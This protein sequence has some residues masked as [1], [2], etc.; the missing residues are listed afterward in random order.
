MSD[1]GQS[2]AR[3]HKFLNDLAESPPLVP[4]EPELLPM[5]FDA[6]RDNSTAT[7]QDIA[8]L[9]AKSQNLATRLLNIAN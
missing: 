6:T 7:L 5:L 9:V 2:L 4:Y 1:P 8:K 3:A